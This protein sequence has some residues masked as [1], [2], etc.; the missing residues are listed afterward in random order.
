M[1]SAPYGYLVTA[2]VIAA[3]TACAVAPRG[4]LGF[5]LGI[6]VGELPFLWAYV[7]IALT[8]LTDA[9]GGL[10]T[11]VGLAGLTL[12]ALSLG[13]LAV[14]ARRSLSTAQALAR[15]LP[16]RR[17]R[18]RVRRALLCP[19]PFRPPAVRRVANIRYGDAGVRNLLDVY[20]HR[21]T[22]TGAP[23][24]IHLHGGALRHG[25]KNRQAL[26]LIHH[27][28]GHGWVCIS[29][30]YRLGPSARFPDH[31]IDVKKV[32]AWAR[33]SAHPYGADGS[34]VVVAGSSAG[35]QLAA[36][37]ALTANDPRFQPGFASADTGVTAAVVLS[38][39]YGRPGA[40][41]APAEHVRPDA[42]PFLVLH[43]DHDTLI[44]AVRAREFVARLGAVSDAEVRYAELPGAQHSF[45]LFHSIRNDTV[46][47]TIEDVLRGAI[48]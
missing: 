27:L 31:L 16:G 5:V 8:W 34:T 37:A 33:A 48:P 4:W 9:G 25:R 45:D 41:D 38:G 44:P 7:L 26:P 10:V 14:L 30:N 21:S 42:P 24:F 22:P 1:D 28:A 6:Q 35:G 15:A 46:V 12:A 3:Y 32:I 40:P 2:A 17:P 36:L 18:L 13:G 11:P 20:H 23:V 19:L 39:Y 43:G 29:A 47:R